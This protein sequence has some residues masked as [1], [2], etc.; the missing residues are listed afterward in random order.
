M[1]SKTSIDLPIMKKHHEK[2]IAQQVE[3][4]FLEEQW[5]PPHVTR[6]KYETITHILN[7]LGDLMLTD[8]GWTADLI[9]GQNIGE[10]CLA[11]YYL[12]SASKLPVEFKANGT[13]FQIKEIG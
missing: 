1:T 7:N 6:G 13:L 12:S 4:Y 5:Q 8:Q 11:A 2:W 3:K 9:G 10:A